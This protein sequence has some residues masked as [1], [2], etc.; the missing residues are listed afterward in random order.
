MII[1][2]NLPRFGKLLN[3]RET[4]ACL[5]VITECYRIL[6]TV[7]LTFSP[8]AL[9]ESFWRAGGRVEV[10]KYSSH[11]RMYM[12]LFWL[13]NRWPQ[14]DINSLDNAPAYTV[15]LP[16]DLRLFEIAIGVRLP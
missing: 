13:H 4:E 7:P 2:Y 11:I 9:F 14:T 1:Y 8:A 10:F 15:L 12:V 6:R 3:Q 5:I 16:K